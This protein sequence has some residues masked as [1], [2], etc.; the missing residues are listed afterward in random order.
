MKKFIFF[1]SLIFIISLS[2][3][4]GSYNNDKYYF[5]MAVNTSNESYC[6]KVTSKF[7]P[8]RTSYFIREFTITDDGRIILEYSREE[9]YVFLAQNK[10][11]I[12][13]CKKLPDYKNKIN[14][15]IAEVAKF[16]KNAEK[17]EMMMGEDKDSLR[18]HCYRE[19]GI[20]L[21]NP[22]YCLVDNENLDSGE[23]NLAASC[24]EEIAKEIEDLE[25]ALSICELSPTYI[26]NCYS[27]LAASRKDKSICEKITDKDKK[28]SCIEVVDALIQL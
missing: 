11:D 22:D 4:V 24:I 17:C 21:K 3:C 13:I 8:N 28:D 10:N 25:E 20:I 6:E 12:E 14:L 7:V 2:G 27:A 9:C 16:N 23:R 26:D 15:C 19:L 18:R 1:I 5:E